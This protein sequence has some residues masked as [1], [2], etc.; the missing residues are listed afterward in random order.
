MT[1][2]AFSTLVLAVC[3]YAAAAI[4]AAVAS[5]E[6]DMSS[7]TNSHA[8]MGQAGHDGH[9]SDAQDTH[10]ETM[11]MDHSDMAGDMDHSGHGESAEMSGHDH[12]KMM[13]AQEMSEED[14]AAMVRVDE[15]LGNYID[16]SA[17]F[18]DENNQPVDLKTLFDKP[19]VLLPIFFLCPAVCNMLQAELTN[20]LNQ[21]GDVPGQDFNVI[22]FSFSDDEDAS[23]AMTSK[24]NYT[25]LIERDMD[26]DKWLYLT[27]DRE[28]I[29]KLTRSLGFYFVKQEKNGYIHPNVLIVMA[30]DGKIIRYLYGPEFLPFDVGMALSEARKGE[31]GI[32]IKRGVLSFCFDYDPENKTYVFKMFRITGTA[33]LIILV[34][35]ILFLASPSRS[36]K[37]R[38]RQHK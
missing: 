29:L 37:K 5:T 9:V 34:G 23:H 19:V 1:A 26:I 11:S 8:N 6:H 10:H 4:P 30:Q 24:Q 33:I 15:Q 32:S 38:G 25:N 13:Q 14:L 21:V 2:R 28:N 22:T 16:F 3:L 17:R 12:E 18:R 31:P 36:K 35:F 7:H 27:G 20:V